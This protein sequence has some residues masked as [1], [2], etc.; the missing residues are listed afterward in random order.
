MPSGRKNDPPPT[1][2]SY[3]EL[4]LRWTSTPSALIHANG[5][6]SL[7]TSAHSSGPRVSASRSPS[8][9]DL[10]SCSGRPA[11]VEELQTAV[12]AVGADESRHQLVG[13]VRQHEL[14]VGV[15]QQRAAPT[16]HRD[17]V[18]ELDRLVDVVGDEHDGFAEFALQPQDLG[19]Q[20]LAHHRVHRG[21]RFVH[22]KDRRV[23]GQR[24]GHADA[25][26]LTA[27][28]LG[29]VAV[30]QLG[31]EPDAFHHLQRGLARAS[32]GF[33]AQHR[34][35][36]HVVDHPKVWHQAGALD[37]VTDPQPQL[38]RIDLGDVLPVDR[39]RAR[40][41]VDHPVDHPHRRGLAT[42]GR[43]DEHGQRPLRHLQRQV[44][45]RDGAVRVFLGDVLEGDHALTSA[46]ACRSRCP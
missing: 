35:G 1:V 23:G 18:A 9:T 6:L 7:M 16:E 22:Q 4:P 44:V 3:S 12:A 10:M 24:P 43:P 42:A 36:R 13:R 46:R 2:L 26:L 25:L 34:D 37:H 39:Q 45:D 40:R 15:L 41:R 33:A 28:Q 29:R 19:L 32:P 31:V 27:R 17:L 11:R 8:A 38:D 20:I 30:S 14:R 5:L 21:E